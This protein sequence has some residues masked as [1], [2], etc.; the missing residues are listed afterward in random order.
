MPDSSSHQIVDHEKKKTPIISTASL[1]PLG[2]VGAVFTI[3]V[4]IPLYS[5]IWLDEK[6]DT[7]KQFVEQKTDEA[8]EI[9]QKHFDK[10]VEYKTETTKRL[11]KLEEKLETQNKTIQDR[12]TLSNQ[13]I[14]YLE[15]KQRN[16]TIDLPDPRRV[17]AGQSGT[18]IP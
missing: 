1:M 5:Y 4:S 17:A 13:T 7:F 8:K 15:A 11:D 16:P 3:L 2:T 14:W 9:E 12:W 18:F 6:F 10:I